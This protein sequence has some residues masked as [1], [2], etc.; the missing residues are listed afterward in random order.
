MAVGR[1]T[2]AGPVADAWRLNPATRLLDAVSIEMTAAGFRL[3]PP[4][5][6]VPWEAVDRLKTYKL[7]LVATDLICLAVDIAGPT[8][9][10]VPHEE[11]PGWAQMTT[12]LA[13]RLPGVPPDCGQPTPGGRPG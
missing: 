9:E 6:A 13:A 7:D 12:E 5:S 1:E 8:A 11:M 2:P 10:R 3:C 4:G